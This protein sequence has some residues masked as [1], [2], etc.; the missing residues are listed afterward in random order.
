MFLW[1]KKTDEPPVRVAI[2]SE[3]SWQHLWFDCSYAFSYNLGTLLT[4]ARSGTVSQHQVWRMG[5]V[6]LA[7]L[8]RVHSRPLWK[9]FFFI[10]QHMTR[11]GSREF[12][13]RR[14][15]CTS[16]AIS[17][18][19]EPLEVS[20]SY[21]R[22]AEPTTESLLTGSIDCAMVVGQHED[23]FQDLGWSFSFANLSQANSLAGICLDA[24]VAEANSHIAQRRSSKADV[25]RYAAL[26]IKN[27]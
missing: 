17:Q 13:N 6:S 25:C 7:Q 20:C 5:S 27:F 18:A 22:Q 14:P 12:T 9:D 1:K 26:C 3:S 21:I 2:W 8:D 4:A 11:L 16:S 19:M 23:K 15:R 24:A 10:H